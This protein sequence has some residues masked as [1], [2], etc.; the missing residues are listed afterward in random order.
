MFLLLRMNPM[1][2]EMNF[3]NEKRT[4]CLIMDNKEQTS[5]CRMRLRIVEFVL[6]VPWNLRK[7]IIIFNFS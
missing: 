6:H 4:S 5:G 7:A 3:T 1:L 2:V